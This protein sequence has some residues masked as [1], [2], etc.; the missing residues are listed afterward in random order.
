[1]VIIVSGPLNNF[2]ITNTSEKKGAEIH[3]VLAMKVEKAWFYEEGQRN[4]RETLTVRMYFLVQPNGPCSTTQNERRDILWFLVIKLQSALVVTHLAPDESGG[5]LG[6]ELDIV[7]QLVESH[8]F[9]YV[10]RE[11][12][13]IG[14]GAA[15]GE[16]LIIAQCADFVHVALVEKDR[17]GHLG[18]SRYH[19]E[20]A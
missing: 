15:G 2:T 4:A 19:H 9:G 17:T 3:A 8:V 12:Y 1:M 11:G 10:L 20:P 16:Q 5:R 7:I 13:A 18:V 14:L 6:I